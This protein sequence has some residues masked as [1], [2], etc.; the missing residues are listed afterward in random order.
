MFL[1]GKICGEDTECNESALIIKVFG[2][3]QGYPNSWNR[4]SRSEFPS[5]V[6]VE[7]LCVISQVFSKHLLILKT[8]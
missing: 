3:K 2:G 8:D 4:L 1:S 6:A 5:K 7:L